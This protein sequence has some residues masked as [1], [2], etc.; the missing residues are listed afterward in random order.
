MHVPHGLS[1][2]KTHGLEHHR[3]TPTRPRPGNG[4]APT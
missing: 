3:L 2:I 1:G 4:N